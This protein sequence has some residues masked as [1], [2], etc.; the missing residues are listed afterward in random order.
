VHRIHESPPRRPSS[1][2]LAG[3]LVALGLLDG[4]GGRRASRARAR[5]SRSERAVRQPR[6]ALDPPARA[7]H[8]A[9]RALQRAL[10]AALCARLRALSALHARRSAAIPT[11]P[12]TARSWPALAGDRPALHA[13]TRAEAIALRSSYRERVAMAAEREMGR[14]SRA[15]CVR[16]H[17]ESCTKEP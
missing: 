3:E 14:S 10:D 17:V 7:A 15:C 2:N 12:C 8:D 5:A 13:R 16:D 6:R 1:A 11:S 4:A 9:A